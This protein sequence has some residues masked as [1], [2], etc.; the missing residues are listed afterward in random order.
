MI[1]GVLISGLVPNTK[2]PVPVSSVTALIK[3]ALEGVARNVATPV[4]KPDTA[5][6]IA[7]FEIVL[8]EP[9]MVLFV[10]VSATSFN[11]V[12]FQ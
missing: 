6:L 7:I 11:R 5:V 8:F 1:I 10:R 4:P 2:A 12:P 9:L 3:L